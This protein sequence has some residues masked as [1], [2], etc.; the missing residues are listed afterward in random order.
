MHLE[1]EN[2]KD[3][4]IVHMKGELDHHTSEKVRNIIDDRLGRESIIKLIMDFSQVMFMDSSGI[5]V[6]IGRYKKLSTKNGSICITNVND[7]IKRIFEI[8]GML[9]IVSI[10]DDV[11]NALENI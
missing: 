8:S 10:Y 4:L 5:G 9:K 3:M 2:N 7:N 11:E 1:F 6:V